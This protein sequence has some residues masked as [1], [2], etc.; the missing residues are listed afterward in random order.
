MN[1]AIK[2]L[3]VDDDEDDF[4]LTRDFFLEIRGRKYEL[5]WASSYERAL[6]II[7]QQRHDVY[8]FDYRLGGRNGVDL[9]KEVQAGGNSVPVILLTGQ[10]EDDVD[11]EAMHAGAED[12]LVKTELNPKSLERAV[13]YAIERKRSEKEIQKLAAF[14]RWNPNPVLEF[15]AEGKL[16]YSNDAAQSLAESLGKTLLAEILPPDVSRIVSECFSSGGK[17]TNLQTSIKDRTFAWSFIPIRASNVVHCYATEITERLNLEAQLRHSMKMEAVGQ[18]AAGV[19]HDFNNILTVIQGHADLLL[20]KINSDPQSENPLKQICLASERAGNL[21]RQLLMFSRKQVM[22]HRFLDLNEVISNLMQMLQRFLGEHISMQ[23][24]SAPD[25][26]MIYG[27]TGMIEQV[28]MNLAVNARDAM[29]KGGCLGIRTAMARFDKSMPPKNPEARCGDFICLTVSDTG[30]GMSDETLS[31]I[32]EPFFTTKEVGKGTGLGLATVYGIIKQHHGWVEVESRTG[33]GSAFK[34]YL[35]AAENKSASKPKAPSQLFA[36][37]GDETILVVEDEPALRMLVVEILQLYGYRVFQ[38]PSG[39]VALEI[40][41]E[42]KTEINLLLTDMVMPDGISG[43]ELADMLL[44]ENPDLRIIYTSGYSPGM[45]GKDTALLAGFNFLPKPYPP[46]RL[47]E[48]VRLCLNKSNE[49]A[50]PHPG[51]SC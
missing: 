27:D 20:H 13:R 12:F 21:I 46:S 6:E 48:V 39:V 17:K 38:A 37:G 30:C 42:H 28:L 18:L 3:L 29:P 45:A 50:K 8:L 19:A 23:I 34:I 32:F 24:N 22:Q 5:E 4:V 7:R 10:S 31:R 14:P 16:T 51:S 41:K 35:P 36:Q 25:L 1:R 26:P 33:E 9:L 11:V 2:V 44:A 15:S 49:N 43:R 40:W 47:A